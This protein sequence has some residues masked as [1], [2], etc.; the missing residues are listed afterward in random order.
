ML[1]GTMHCITEMISRGWI[2]LQANSYVPM[3]SE[4]QLIH[5]SG[6]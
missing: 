3:T 2:K 1:A 6:G 4:D 5:N